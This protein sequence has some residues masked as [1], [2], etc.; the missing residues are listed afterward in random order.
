MVSK[1]SSLE[2]LAWQRRSITHSNLGLELESLGSNAICLAA[3][4]R[5]KS[6]DTISFVKLYWFRSLL[7]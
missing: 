3:V 2:T 4:E 1:V 7:N 5:D 6:Y